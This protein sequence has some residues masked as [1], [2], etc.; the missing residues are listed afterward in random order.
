MRGGRLALIAAAGTAVAGAALGLLVAAP[1]GAVAGAGIWLVASCLAVSVLV[2]GLVAFWPL[3]R[4]S[5]IAMV[6]TAYFGV[7][8]GALCVCAVLDPGSR[9]SI[10]VGLIWFMPLQAFNQIAN[11]GRAARLLGRLFV[12]APPA[13]IGLLSPWLIA[14]FPPP[15]LVLLLVCGLANI[16]SAVMLNLLWRNREAFISE[17]EVSSRFR[18]AAAILEGLSESFILVD[19]AYRLLYLSETAAR[20]LG[21]HRGAAEGRPL[22]EA[23]ALF[24]SPVIA[25]A[26]ERAWSGEGPLQFEV[27]IAGRCYEIR[28]TPAQD[29]MSVYF[30]DV[31]ERRD[32]REN[33]RRSE[34]LLQMASRMAR[35]GGWEYALA[36]G[37]VVLSD[38]VA[39]IFEIPPGVI[40]SLEEAI[41]S[42]APDSQ[43][44]VRD[45][46]ER[47]LAEGAPYDDEFQVVTATGRRIW[48]RVIGQAIRDADGAIL[49]VQGAFQDITEQRATLNALRTG[50][51]RLA[52]QAEV[53]D[54]AHDAIVVRD[55]A[56]RILYWN[57][58]AVRLYG[59]TSEEAVGRPLHEVL[60]IDPAHT[61]AVTARLL[62]TGEWRRPVDLI[63]RDGRRVIID[64]HL[65]LVRDEAGQPKSVLAINTDITAQVAVEERLRQAERLEAIGQ[66]T[67]GVA[68]DFNNLL[69]VILGNAEIIGDALHEQ[70]DLHALVMMIKRAA[71]RG[72]T[73]TRRILAFAR[74]QEL[75]PRSVDI[76]SLLAETGPLLRRAMG[77]DVALTLV[78]GAG[79]WDALVDPAQLENALL[80]LS[81]NA[82]DA[83]PDGGTLTIET[84]NIELDQAYADTHGEV[85]P[86]EYVAITV[87]DSGTGIAPQNL[88]RVFDPFF[89]TKAFGQGTGLGLSMVYG[90]VKQ[91]RGHVAIYSEV[92]HGTSVTM[93]LPRAASPAVTQIEQPAAL[94]S[95]GGSETILVVED[96]DL[97]RRNVERQLT[98]LGYRVIT[99]VHGGE[100]LEVIR[101]GSP[102]DL[103]FTDVIMPGGL[104]GPA[105][106]AAAR[107]ALPSLKLLYTSGYTEHAI[108]RQGR[109]DLGAPLLNK[110]YVR[111]ELAL[112][113]R[114]ALATSS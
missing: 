37:R 56:G 41:A 4:L 74:R 46:F 23:L 96:D 6:A 32:T 43:S 11:R 30:K 49:G 98:S 54:K 86:G 60:G 68:H 110:P 94:K 2:L 29:D 25:P 50:E 8:L 73:L 63:A 112:K 88:S 108:G 100:A 109:L 44:R 42:Y 57:E 9:I 53:L 76:P 83:M 35:M 101:S 39:S 24:A 102:I 18:F 64:S 19:R 28:C 77:E 21:V 90:F 40:V 80:N 3:N 5:T 69:T 34:A 15:L 59:L 70:E 104:D 72:A 91:S 16:A 82:R 38:Q 58:S 33:L 48:V 1:G 84:A 78:E 22:G 62:E 87:T 79:V 114:A 26:L 105:L 17:Q 99:S 95:L 85:S 7:Y 93:Y 89:T 20:A 36:D 75:E 14:I 65:S 61:A 81:L 103:L 10:F 67:G 47:C 51:L 111:S 66:F 113:V 27:E 106:A 45:L 97:L 52:E 12:V 55:M 107:E 31:T 13:I 92:G 71:Q